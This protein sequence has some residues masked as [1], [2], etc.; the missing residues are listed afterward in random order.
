MGEAIKTG[1][2]ELLTERR[3]RGTDVLLIA[4]PRARRDVAA[5]ARRALVP[6]P[7]HRLRQPRCGAHAVARRAALGA[8]DGRHRRA[9]ARAGGPDRREEQAERAARLFGVADALSE[10][11]GAGISWS[12]LRSLNERDLATIRKTL[13]PEAFEAA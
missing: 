10:K 3:G 2:L 7:P 9:S 6:L 8:H 12:V 13:D 4:G 11:T 5:P 1:D